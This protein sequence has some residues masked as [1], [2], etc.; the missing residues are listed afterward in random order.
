[1]CNGI[2]QGLLLGCVVL[3]TTVGRDNL[4]RAVHLG[5]GKGYVLMGF[6]RVMV[7]HRDL[8]GVACGIIGKAAYPELEVFYE[9]YDTVDKRLEEVLKSLLDNKEFGIVYITDLSPKQQHIVD[10]L[11]KFNTGD[12]R[13]VLLLDHH[14]TAKDRLKDYSWANFKTDCCGAMILFDW[15]MGCT[16]APRVQRFRVFIK[17]V[18]DYDMWHHNYPESR[19]LNYLLAAMGME[20]F[21]KRCL[22][23][24][25]D[26][27]NE[28]DDLLI[29]IHMQ[30]LEK[31]CKRS[32]E[33]M[34]EHRDEYGYRVGVV[35]C[36]NHYASEVGHYILSRAD[37]DYVAMIDMR[38]MS[39]SMRSKKVDIGKIAEAKGGG[40]HKLSAG[41]NI[42]TQNVGGLL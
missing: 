36:E 20:L 15:L 34:V 33:T 17:L 23:R 6:R 19:L 18:N 3:N 16:C 4:R 22:T 35:F 14:Q 28:T 41:Y 27:I 7:T 13:S 30:K 2:F 21:I 26:Y 37:L 12:A 31:Y 42:Q 29:K 11:D 38:R 39:V 9:N 5:L 25:A 32:L 24:P 1:M 40:G 10:M 8:D